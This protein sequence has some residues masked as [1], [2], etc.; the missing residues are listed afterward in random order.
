MSIDSP[1]DHKEREC[2]PIFNSL[3]RESTGSSK[4]LPPCQ[5]SR[6]EFSRRDLYIIGTTNKNVKRFS[7][8]R[9]VPASSALPQNR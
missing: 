9:P 1:T 8:M 3:M 2:L 6:S 5:R 7:R 4:S